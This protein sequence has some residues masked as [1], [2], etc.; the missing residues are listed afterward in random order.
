MS[1][2]FGN[3]SMIERNVGSVTGQN[4]SLFPEIILDRIQMDH[5]ASAEPQKLLSSYEE[6]AEEYFPNTTFKP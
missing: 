6:G 2:G 5:A 3:S 1:H 4:L